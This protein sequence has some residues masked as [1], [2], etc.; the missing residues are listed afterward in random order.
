MLASADECGALSLGMKARVLSLSRMVFATI[1]RD[2]VSHK[3]QGHLITR[4]VQ[5]SSIA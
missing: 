2:N 1:L 4:V 3:I 5:V